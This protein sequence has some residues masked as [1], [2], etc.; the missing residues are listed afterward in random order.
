MKPEF[1]TCSILIYFFSP[2]IQVTLVT[3]YSVYRVQW[4]TT[5]FTTY[6]SMEETT[7]KGQV[8]ADSDCEEET[9]NLGVNTCVGGVTIY[10]DSDTPT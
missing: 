7:D 5:L 8:K 1:S 9:N 2:D 4:F 6:I 3:L 10:L